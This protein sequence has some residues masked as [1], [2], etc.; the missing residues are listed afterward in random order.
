M[1]EWMHKTMEFMLF[2]RSISSACVCVGVCVWVQKTGNSL[3][4]GLID[5][6]N[7]IFGL[8]AIHSRVPWKPLSAPGSNLFFCDCWS[9]KWFECGHSYMCSP[10][11]LQYVWIYFHACVLLYDAVGEFVAY[12]SQ[13]IPW[14]LPS[15]SKMSPAH[16]WVWAKLLPHS[17]MA[18]EH[19]LN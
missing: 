9:E 13:L 10:Y 6:H 7:G 11:S 2:M 8:K 15:I 18:P 3:C 16:C 14:A 19:Y 17:P 1:N 12:W 4:A 5:D